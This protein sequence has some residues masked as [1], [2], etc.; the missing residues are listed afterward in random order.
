MERGASA[1]SLG[2]PL[3]SEQSADTEPE[4]RTVIDTEVIEHSRIDQKQCVFSELA[5]ESAPNRFHWY[6]RVLPASM[7]CQNQGLDKPALFSLI[8]DFVQVINHLTLN[9]C[10][11]RPH[12]AHLKY[13]P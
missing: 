8:M 7:D 11:S 1:F 9:A 10:K 4:K 2:L 6:R 13:L 12:K 3:P 5:E